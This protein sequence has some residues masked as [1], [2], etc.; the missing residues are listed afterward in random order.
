MVCKHLLNAASNISFPEEGILGDWPTVR[1]QHFAQ[2]GNNDVHIGSQQE[3]PIGYDL[4]SL[5]SILRMHPMGTTNV[6]F[7]HY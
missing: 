7:G 5:R 1:Q 3:A 2:Y 4:C 6:P